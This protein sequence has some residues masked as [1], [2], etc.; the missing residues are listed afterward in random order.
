MNKACVI[1]YPI[2][3]SL[4]PELHNY[5]LNFYNIKGSYTKEAI[6]PEN[7]GKFIDD[8]KQGKFVGGNV[9]VPHKEAIIP[10]IDEPCPIVKRLGAANTIWLEDGK[11][12]ATNTDGFGFMAHLKASADSF[13]AKE[14]KALII[15]S[16]GAAKAV[17]DS[18]CDAGVP[19][20]IIANRNVDRA[21]ATAEHFSSHWPQTKIT[22]QN[23]DIDGD[24]I[25]CSNLIVNTSVLGMKGQPTLDLDISSAQKNTIIYD[26]VYSPLETN[27]LSQAKKH[28]LICIDGLGM[29][30]HQGRPGFKIWFDFFPEVNSELKDKILI[31]SNK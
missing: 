31:K 25:A 15:G 14:T 1:G 7:L 17:I 11:I 8:V 9:T 18:L 13:I 12:H 6:E 3:H 23:L 10:F 2:S 19:N 29:L 27:L 5:W 20:I 28:G 30:L 24:Q 16:G 26:L 4:S 21:K 22:A